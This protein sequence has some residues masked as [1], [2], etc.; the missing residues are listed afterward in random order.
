MVYRH[1]I[2]ATTYVFN[3]LRDLLAKATPPRS[4]DR[5]AGIAAVSEPQMV[6]AFPTTIGWR[7]R[8]SARL[9][10]NHPL[11]DAKGRAASIRAGILRGSGDACTGTNPPRDDP[12]VIGGLSRLL[13]DII[14]RLQ[15]PTQ[16][17]VLTH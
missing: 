14:A 17:C 10:P 9:Q 12:A 11:A 5:L 7:G 6:P 4:G 1:A 3:D 16:S 13:D 8:R 15:I 2:D